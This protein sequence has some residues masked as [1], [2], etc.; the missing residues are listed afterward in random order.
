MGVDVVIVT[1]GSWAEGFNVPI[2]LRIPRVSIWSVL[3]PSGDC[4]KLT[5]CRSVSEVAYCGLTKTV[6]YMRNPIIQGP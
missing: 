4:G 3:L 2:V 1:S 6:L 5:G